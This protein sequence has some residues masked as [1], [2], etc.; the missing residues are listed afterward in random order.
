MHFGVFDLETQR[1]AAQ[2]GGWQ[3]ADRMGI[4]CGVI[5]DAHKD[6]FNEYRENQI[7]RLIADLKKFELIVGFNIKR[8]DYL[9]LKG[10]SDFDFTTLNTLDILE[11]I[12][13]QLGFRLSLAHVAQETL[14]TTKTG[15]GL[16]ALRWW[17]EGRLREIIDYCK[18]D[19][20]LTRDLY[21]FGRQNGYLIFRNRDQKQVRIP[22]NWHTERFLK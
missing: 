16:Q 5:Y 17:K 11:D 22:V 2:V 8:F 21:L 18:M 7:S 9:V 15:D 20:K 4:S 12:H 19:V 10:Y 6:V 13:H 3:R 14:G 1:S